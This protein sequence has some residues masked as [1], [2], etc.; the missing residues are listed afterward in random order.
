MENKSWGSFSWLISWFHRGKTGW[1][2]QW[3]L[4]LH[5]EN[6]GND[7]IWSIWLIFFKWAVEPPTRKD[8]APWGWTLSSWPVIEG[9]ERRVMVG[10]ND[11]EGESGVP[12]C[13]FFRTIIFGW[14][15]HKWFGNPIKTGA[16][17]VNEIEN[18]YYTQGSNHLLRMVMEPKFFAEEVI[19]IILWQG[20][21]IPTNR[22]IID[23]GKISPQQSGVLQGWL[24]TFLFGTSIWSN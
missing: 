1:W 18:Q 12:L 19:A 24:P 2:F 8:L 20:D 9:E 11:R 16:F 4:I 17:L 14:M 22:F 3:F 23:V 13:C 15:V 21:W 7:P 6:W 10:K 5:P